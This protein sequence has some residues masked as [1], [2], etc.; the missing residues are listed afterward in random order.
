MGLWENPVRLVNVLEGAPHT[1]KVHEVDAA[2]QDIRCATAY[3][4][5]DRLEAA[6]V[7]GWILLLAQPCCRLLEVPEV[8]VPLAHDT[9]LEAERTEARDV[10]FPKL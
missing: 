2:A 10:L 5:A 7:K 9:A 6:N 8:V 3:S 1:D 4:P